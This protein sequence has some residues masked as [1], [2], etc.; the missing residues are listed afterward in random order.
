MKRKNL[1][2]WKCYHLFQ[3]PTL[4]FFIQKDN[5]TKLTLPKGVEKLIR[6]WKKKLD[7]WNSWIIYLHGVN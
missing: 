4:Y 3:N 1:Y 6:N 2:F 7:H 5:E